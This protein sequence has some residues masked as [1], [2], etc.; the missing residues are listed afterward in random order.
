MNWQNNDDGEFKV[1]RCRR[2]CKISR[3]CIYYLAAPCLLPN[4]RWV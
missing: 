2:F 4:A 3:M 1:L